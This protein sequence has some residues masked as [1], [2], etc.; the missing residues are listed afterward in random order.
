M[1]AIPLPESLWK[2]REAVIDAFLNGREAE[3][4]LKQIKDWLNLDGWDCLL[5]RWESILDIQQIKQYLNDKEFAMG[6]VGEDIE[7]R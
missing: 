6:W 1:S 2:A 4:E 7:M 3:D 5:E